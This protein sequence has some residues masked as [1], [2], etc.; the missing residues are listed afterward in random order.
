MKKFSG[1]QFS[2]HYAFVTNF[3]FRCKPSMK[4]GHVH[5]HARNVLERKLNKSK[6]SRN[7]CHNYIN[8]R[9]R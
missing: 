3:N 6:S 7:R 8:R 4:G 5:N 1:V 2:L 9:M